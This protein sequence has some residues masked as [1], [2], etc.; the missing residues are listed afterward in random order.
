MKK[1]KINTV[2]HS[3]ATYGDIYSL[4]MLNQILNKVDF[5]DI[6]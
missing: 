1:S 2:L 5:S 6:K 4:K 3:N